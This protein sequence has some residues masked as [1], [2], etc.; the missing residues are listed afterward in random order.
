MGYLWC[1]WN[2]FLS[3]IE[4][5]SVY[6]LYLEYTTLSIA[7]Y[8]KQ[9][10]LKCMY[11]KFKNT[12]IEYKNVSGRLFLDF[13]FSF[14]V[15]DITGCQVKHFFWIKLFKQDWLYKKHY[16]IIHTLTGNQICVTLIVRHISPL[17]TKHAKYP[18]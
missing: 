8:Y 4:F 16:C 13:F 15:F 6:I 2:H 18:K 3:I 11:A 7:L 5:F 17:L 9:F 10:D 14:L 1:A 12:G